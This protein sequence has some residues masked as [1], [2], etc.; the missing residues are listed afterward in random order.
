VTNSFVGDRELADIDN[1][2]DLTDAGGGKIFYEQ[3]LREYLQ[4]T[5][6]FPETDLFGDGS[7]IVP[8][9]QDSDS[10]YQVNGEGRITINP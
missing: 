3:S 1:Q 4:D 7:L 9:V 5:A 10:R 8:T 6:N 2:E